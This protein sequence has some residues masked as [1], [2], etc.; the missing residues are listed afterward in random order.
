MP[1]IIRKVANENRFRVTNALT[2]K[3]VAKRTTKDKAK[4]QVRLLMSLD[5]KK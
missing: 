3:V 1:Y 5:A 4:A 2:G